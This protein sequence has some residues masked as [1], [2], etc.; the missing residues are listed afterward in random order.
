[1]FDDVL[2]RLSDE[3]VRFLVTGGGAVSFHGYHRSVEDLDIV[4]DRAA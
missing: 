3:K 1:M 4:V 2:V